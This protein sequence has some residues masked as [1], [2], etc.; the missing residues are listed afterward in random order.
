[1]SDICGALQEH[2]SWELALGPVVGEV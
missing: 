1:V 2:V